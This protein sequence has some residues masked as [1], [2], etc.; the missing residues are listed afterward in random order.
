[1]KKCKNCKQPF[2]PKFSTLEKYC[3]QVECQAKRAIENLKTMKAKPKTA[4]ARE[5]KVRTENL[6]SLGDWKKILQTIFNRYIR[7]RDAKKG[8]ISCGANLNGKYDAGHFFSVGAFPNLRYDEDNVHGQCVRC[9]MYYHGNL[10]KYREGLI[11]RIGEQRFR[12]LEQKKTEPLHL[13][14]DETI[15]KINQYKQKIKSINV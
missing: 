6:R 10:S 12:V 15:E 9:N 14:M 8:C 4:W 7:L 11:A 5:K 13:T 2:T 3:T 1:M